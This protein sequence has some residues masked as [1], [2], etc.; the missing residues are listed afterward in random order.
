MFTALISGALTATALMSG[1]PLAD[2]PVQP[3]ATSS[4]VVTVV[5]EV[6]TMPHFWSSTSFGELTCPPHAPFLEG[7]NYSDGLPPGVAA[8]TFGGDG[9]HMA[10]VT[11]YYPVHGGRAIG[12]AYAT[13][14]NW[15]LP[16]ASRTVQLVA[17]CVAN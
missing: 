4:A 5:S 7:R 6:K 9:V 16:E 14:T 3:I 8:R 17:H 12:I 13:A 15:A 11:K 10:S 2:T 1:L